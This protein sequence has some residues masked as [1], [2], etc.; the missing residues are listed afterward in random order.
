MVCRCRTRCCVCTAIPS[1]RGGYGET[2]STFTAVCPPQPSAC[3]SFPHPC[4]S[5]G[6][7]DGLVVVKECTGKGV[8]GDGVA[9]RPLGP[10]LD[11][12]RGR[13]EN[14]GPLVKG[15][16]SQDVDLRPLANARASEAQFSVP[17][18]V[19]D[20]LPVAVGA[21]PCRRRHFL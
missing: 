2:R 17:V 1:R 18:G 11:D 6:E 14:P 20:R 21:Q 3:R 5:G 15:L 4:P 9:E 7:D 8:G 10:S 13:G 12:V 19:N 16:G